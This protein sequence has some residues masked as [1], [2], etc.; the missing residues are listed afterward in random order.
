MKYT[1]KTIVR[2][3]GRTAV[4]PALKTGEH[5][6][7]FAAWTQRMTQSTL[8]EILALIARPGLL[9]FALG[10]PAPELFPVRAYAR[11]AQRVLDE[12]PDAL[13]YGCM[14]AMSGTMGMIQRQL[15]KR[16]AQAPRFT[17]AAWT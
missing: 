7:A 17:A 15:F 11:A 12:D 13:Q 14:G 3:L 6:M 10:M 1:R 9:S 4:T 8:R 5:E 16:P 2:I